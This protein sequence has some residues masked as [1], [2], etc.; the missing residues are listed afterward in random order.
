MDSLLDGGIRFIIFLQGLGDWLAGPLRFLSTLGN[1]QF[2]L[3]VMPILYWCV[4][5][6][7]GLRVGILLLVSNSLNGVFK[8]LFQA[9]RPYFYSSLVRALSSETSFGLPSGHAQN[10]A[11][12][13]GLLAALVQRRWPRYRR[14]AWLLA[15]LLAF[16][17]GFSRIYLGVHFPHDVLAGWAL[18]ALLVWAFLKLESPVKDW[19]ARQGTASR[20]LAA[21]GASL[22]LLLLAGAARLSLGDWTVPQEWLDNIA[23]AGENLPL[24]NPLA[25]EGIVTS[26]GALFGLAAGVI[27]LQAQGGF[28]SAGTWVKRLARFPI[29]LAGV[30]LLRYGLG[31]IFPDGEALLPYLL[32]FVRYSLIGF[33]MAGLAPWAFVRLGLAERQNQLPRSPALVRVSSTKE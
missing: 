6:A 31:A 14:L 20:L 21:F 26:A 11:A 15:I 29:G 9:P 30:L 5:A 19:L 1:E 16:L 22:L 7:I 17:I 4:D 2:F 25:L 27:W 24:P 32:R 28:L 8:L 33:W 18:G 23:K 12:V 10:S 3:L 13:W